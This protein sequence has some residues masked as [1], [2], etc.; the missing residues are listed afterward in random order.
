MAKPAGTKTLPPLKL[1]PEDD[2]WRD[3]DHKRAI[4]A[5]KRLAG[6]WSDVDGEKLA[7]DFRRWRK[8]GSR[9]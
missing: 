4:A 6:L 7:D 8:E 2:I 3:Y 9:P 1:A 5:L